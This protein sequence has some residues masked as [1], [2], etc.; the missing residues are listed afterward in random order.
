MQVEVIAS[1][2]KHV[3][4]PASKTIALIMV[5]FASFVAIKSSMY[6]FQAISGYF[7]VLARNCLAST[8]DYIVIQ[9][10]KLTASEKGYSSKSN[11]RP[12]WGSNPR[13]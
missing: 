5:N 11:Q 8:L 12:T 9:V 13:P 6:T 3:G 4:Q 2:G 1:N 7:V 10:K